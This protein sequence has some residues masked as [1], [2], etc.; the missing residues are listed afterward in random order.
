[1][2]FQ[3]NSSNP[4][5]A[6]FWGL[7]V[8]IVTLGTCSRQIYSWAL[9][10][11]RKLVYCCTVND[12]VYAL[13]H[14][15]AAARLKQAD[16]IT[17]DGMPLVWR[18]RQKG[19]EVNRVYAPDLMLVVLKL[20]EGTPVR[21]F[22][23][24][25][26]RETL[27]KLKTRISNRFPACRLLGFVSPPFRKLTPDE[28]N[29]YIRNIRQISPQILWVGLGSEKQIK[30]ASR[31][32]DRLNPC[33]IIT[34]GA[35]FDFLAKTKPQ[36]PKVIRNMGM[37]WLFRLIT[38]PRRLWRRYLNNIYKLGCFLIKYGLP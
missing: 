35:A 23:Y 6:P 31:W 4:A 27:N 16:V 8:S 9:S 7:P 18:L 28:E 14:P 17:P 38:E 10:G 29:D 26:S 5:T 30:L 37:E 3:D 20:T 13:S 2:N 21:H 33:V 32:S 1:M 15:A 25:S 36:A 12:M 24:G 34:V 22:F 19:F 11:R